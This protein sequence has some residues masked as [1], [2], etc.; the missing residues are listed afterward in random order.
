MDSQNSIIFKINGKA[1]LEPWAPAL[2]IV[3]L[4]KKVQDMS[5]T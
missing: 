5:P 2:S 4:P 3:L 1:G